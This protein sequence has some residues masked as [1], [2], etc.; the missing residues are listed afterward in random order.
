MMLSIERYGAIQLF[1]ICRMSL[2][3]CAAT[4]GGPR[5]RV[6]AD[7]LVFG[8]GSGSSMSHSYGSLW[9]SFPQANFIEAPFQAIDFA[10]D[11][12]IFRRKP[13]GLASIAPI[14]TLILPDINY[15]PPLLRWW[16]IESSRAKAL[17]K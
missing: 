10:L 2:R 12:R 4:P 3:P 9:C 7:A 13:N 8:F 16:D 14:G 5:R 6:T 1:N 15:S 17:V 11:I